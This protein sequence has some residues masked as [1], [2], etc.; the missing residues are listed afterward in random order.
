M[1][2]PSHPQMSPVLRIN[3]CKTTS[4]PQLAVFLRTKRFFPDSSLK[5]QTLLCRFVKKGK[6]MR[7]YDWNKERLAHAVAEANCWFDCL[8][9]LQ[10]PKVGGNY[11]T[12]KERSGSTDWIRH[13]SIIAWPRPGM[14]S[15]MDGSWSTNQMTRFSGTE[16]RSRQ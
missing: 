9:K 7:K 4:R 3:I 11:M 12:L 8:D 1:S 6:E 5:I 16:H 13:I 10:V 2:Q 15:T 14:G